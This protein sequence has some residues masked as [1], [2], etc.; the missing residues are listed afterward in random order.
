MLTQWPGEASS[1]CVTR[2][3][4]PAMLLQEAGRVVQR[5]GDC[6]VINST[7]HLVCDQASV[8]RNCE[9]LPANLTILQPRRGLLRTGVDPAAIVP[10]SSR[11]CLLQKVTV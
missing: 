10:N 1:V 8:L 5:P 7:A 2:A 3:M 9:A 4:A 6:D 11:C